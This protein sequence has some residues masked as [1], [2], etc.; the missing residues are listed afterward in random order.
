MVELPQDACL[1][2]EGAALLVGAAGSQRLYGHGQLTLTGQL[3]ATAAHLPK[4]ACRG[5]QTEDVNPREI[6]FWPNKQRCKCAA[7]GLQFLRRILR[8]WDKILWFKLLKREYNLVSLILIEV[9]TKIRHSK[10]LTLALKWSEFYFIN[11]T[12]NHLQTP[13]AP[14]YYK[15]GKKMIGMRGKIY[16]GRKMKA[17]N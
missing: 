17:L 7:E 9:R 10:T 11:H 4:V 14:L 1:A 8:I 5:R 15:M 16:K 3:Q 6:L 12:T 2:Q 13:A